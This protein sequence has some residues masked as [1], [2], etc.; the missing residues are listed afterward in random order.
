LAIQLIVVEHV[1]DTMVA[2]DYLIDIGDQ[3]WPKK[4]RNSS[5]CVHQKKCEKMKK[6]VN[7]AYLSGRKFIPA[8]GKTRRI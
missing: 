6:I 7:R 5:F 2:A 1:K 8:Y 3:C 4:V